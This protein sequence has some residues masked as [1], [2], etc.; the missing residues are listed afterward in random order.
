MPLSIGN[1]PSADR[2][3]TEIASVDNAGGHNFLLCNILGDFSGRG[4]NYYFW[5]KK[6]RRMRGSTYSGVSGFHRYPSAE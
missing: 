1:M 3:S 2:A 6:D 5:S 4:K